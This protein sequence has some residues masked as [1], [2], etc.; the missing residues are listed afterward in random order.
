[1]SKIETTSELPLKLICRINLRRRVAPTA[2]KGLNTTRHP[3]ERP[4]KARPAAPDPTIRPHNHQSPPPKPHHRT[5]AR[6]TR[7]TTQTAKT[8]GHPHP[9]PPPVTPTAKPEP[10]LAPTPENN[11]PPQSLHPKAN[12]NCIGPSKKHLQYF[13]FEANFLENENFFQ[14]TELPFFS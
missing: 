3:F 9:P 8:N 13:N 2:R 4:R 14:K 6:K 12:R 1:M 11:P 7:F 5:D 10:T